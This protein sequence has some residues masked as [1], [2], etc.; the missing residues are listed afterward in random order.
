MRPEKP[1]SQHSPQRGPSGGAASRPAADLTETLGRMAPIEHTG[2]MPWV[3]L[4]NAIYHPSIFRKMVGR[5]DTT[6]KNGDLVAVYDRD[7]KRFGSGLLSTQSQIALRML[8]FDDSPID[9]SFI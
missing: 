5:M 8:T 1:F 2:L 7:G 6:V 9:E 3:Q 4:R